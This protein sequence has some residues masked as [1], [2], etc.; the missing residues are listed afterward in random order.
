[1]FTIAFSLYKVDEHTENCT[2]Y[3]F[4]FHSHDIHRL[5]RTCETHTSS[6][7]EILCISTFILIFCFT[8]AFIQS[9]SQCRCGIACDSVLY[10]SALSFASTSN[11]AV[12]EIRSNK[13]IFKKLERE[14]TL[15]KDINSF[16]DET[17][18][19]RDLAVIQAFLVNYFSYFTSNE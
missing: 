14:F 15:T 9:D 13:T 7:S 17:S 18:R 5:D 4:V 12:E 8:E 2:W 6:Q 1:M 3:S 10:D 19:S 11:L 16:L